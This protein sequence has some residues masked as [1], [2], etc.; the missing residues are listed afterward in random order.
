MY[1]SYRAI[2]KSYP[3]INFKARLLPESLL[4]HFD[5]PAPVVGENPIAEGLL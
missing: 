1:V 2:R 3:K 4:R 5:N